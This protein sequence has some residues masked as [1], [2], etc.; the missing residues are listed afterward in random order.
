M[1]VPSKPIPEQAIVV[2][3]D[4]CSSSNIVDDLHASG[5]LHC[6]TAFFTDLRRHL[7]REQ[8]RSLPFNLYKFVGDG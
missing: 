2:V 4:V 8:R 1:A 5:Q 7:D 6:L 3:F